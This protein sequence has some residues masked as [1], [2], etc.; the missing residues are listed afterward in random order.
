[1]PVDSLMLLAQNLADAIQ[2]VLVSQKL[3]WG[4]DVAIVISNDAVHY[5]DED[6][7]GSNYA[8]FGCDSTAYKKALFNEN[9]LI[10]DYLTAELNIPKIC[11]FVKELVDEKSIYKW[12]W[13]G[14]NT[15]PFGLFTSLYLQEKTGEKKLSGYYLGYSTSIMNPPIYVND[16]KMSATAPATIHHWVGYTAIGYE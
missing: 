7:G 6:W 9:R 13:C 5:G 8:F 11:S 1:M 12:T 14:R 2:A 4:K 3:K 16:L 15:I 10:E